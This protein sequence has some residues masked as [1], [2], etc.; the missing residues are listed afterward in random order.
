MISNTGSNDAT[1]KTNGSSRG[2]QVPQI[3][4][5]VAGVAENIAK[6]LEQMIIELNQELNIEYVKRFRTCNSSTVLAMRPGILEKALQKAYP[7]PYNCDDI[8][9][10]EYDG[11]TNDILQAVMGACDKQIISLVDQNNGIVIFD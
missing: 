3:L 8:L 6:R 11:V 9:L 7:I 4:S 1:R 10:I 2:T 5:R